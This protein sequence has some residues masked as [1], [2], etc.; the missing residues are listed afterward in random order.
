[1]ETNLVLDP[2]TFRQLAVLMAMQGM[3]ANPGSPR[4]YKDVAFHA[5]RF[6]DALLE[7]MT[8]EVRGTE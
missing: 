3:L 5:V 1:M 8:I 4:A 7:E 2:G 6:A